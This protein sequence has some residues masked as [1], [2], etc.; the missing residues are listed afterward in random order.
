MGA[1]RGDYVMA[2]TRRMDPRPLHY[3]VT[4]EIRA[5]LVTIAHRQDRPVADVARDIMRTAWLARHKS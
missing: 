5:W 2:R 1:F 4:A 3:H